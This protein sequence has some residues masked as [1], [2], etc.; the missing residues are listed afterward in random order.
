MF[1]GAM[2]TALGGHVFAEGTMPTQSRGH[3]THPVR[4]DA[5]LGCD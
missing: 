1:V 5:V 4:M 2:P 3:G